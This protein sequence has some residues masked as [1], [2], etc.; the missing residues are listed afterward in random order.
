MA[1]GIKYISSKSDAEILALESTDALW[2]DQ[3]F[4][5]PNNTDPIK[6]YYYRVV[7]GIMT[8]YGRTDQEVIDLIVI[9]EEEDSSIPPFNIIAN[10][11]IGVEADRPEP[12]YQSIGDTYITNDS[13]K[14][15]VVNSNMDWNKTDLIKGQFITDVSSSTELPPIYQF[16]N[17]ILMPIANYAPGTLP[18]LPE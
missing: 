14:I 12:Q 9:P 13:L 10:L 2:F 6:P 3:G 15:C 1:V 7:N 5:Y 8:R 16:Y 11:G 4:Y 18:G 17:N